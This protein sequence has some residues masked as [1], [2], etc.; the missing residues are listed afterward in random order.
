MACDTTIL[1]RVPFFSLFDEDE[2]KVLASE[3]EVRTFAPRQRIYK[4]GEA[5]GRAYV[6][7]SGGVRVTTILED[8]SPSVTD[9]VGTYRKYREV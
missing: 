6:L 1:R 9:L 8:Q 4:I 2:L 3:V 7:L 5:P